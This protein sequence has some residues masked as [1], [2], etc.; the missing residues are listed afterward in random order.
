MPKSSIQATDRKT[1]LALRDENKWQMV[2]RNIP[3]LKKC[4]SQGEVMR[5]WQS[6]IQY[7]SLARGS[8]RI[9]LRTHLWYQEH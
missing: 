4:G 2:L 3:G 7:D 8:F 6:L 1:E 5:H 9:A